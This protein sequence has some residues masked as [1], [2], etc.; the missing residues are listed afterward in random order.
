MRIYEVEQDDL[1][2]AVVHTVRGLWVI[3]MDDGKQYYGCHT[4]KQAW[5]AMKK[6]PL[7]TV[8]KI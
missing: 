2:L 8:Y 3:E 6:Q 4:E 5:A 7:R 1:P